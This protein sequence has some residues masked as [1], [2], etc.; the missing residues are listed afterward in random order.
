MVMGLVGDGD[1]DLEVLAWP[2]Q[3][4]RAQ[5]DLQFSSISVSKNVQSCIAK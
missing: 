4:V 1:G 2:V 3:F 5:S